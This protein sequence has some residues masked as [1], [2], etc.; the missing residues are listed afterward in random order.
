V[1]RGKADFLA[2]EGLHFFKAMDTIFPADFA[3]PDK[4]LAAK[5]QR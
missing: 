2:Y 1:F 3:F 5:A 4:P